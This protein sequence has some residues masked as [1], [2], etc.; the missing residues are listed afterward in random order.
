M[1]DR[2]RAW[3]RDRAGNISLGTYIKSVLFSDANPKARQ[4]KSPVKDEKSLADVLA[5]LG[6]SR[7]AS[8]LRHN[9]HLR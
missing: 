7:I 3:L 4:R 9:G 1:T 6:A 2:E 8:N 5:C